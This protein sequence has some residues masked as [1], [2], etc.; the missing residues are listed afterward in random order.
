MNEAT[1]S[2]GAFTTPRRLTQSKTLPVVFWAWAGAIILVLELNIWGNWIFGPNFTPT[3]PGPDPI[4]ELELWYLYGIQALSVLFW[5]YAVWAWIL[6]PSM[7]EGKLTTDAMLAICCWTMWI[8]DPS[9]NYNTTTVLYNSYAVNMGSWTLGSWPGWTSPAG[10]LLP[11]PI[12]V[13]ATGYLCWVYLMVVFPCFLLKKVK[14]RY[15]N[16]GFVPMLALLIAGVMLTDL[17][18][19]V[20]ILR[21]GV[22][23]YPGGIREVTLFAGETYQFPLTEMLTFGGAVAVVAALRFFKNDKGETFV[24][25][26]LDSLNIGQFCQQWIKF[27]GLFGFTHTAFFLVFF[28]PN[29]WFATHSDPWPEGYPSYMINGMCKYGDDRNQCPGPG[30]SI[31]RPENNPF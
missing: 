14:A 5:F 25:R 30:I 24:D 21:T 18:V 7:Q 29:M 28:V 15:P 26:G 3:D 8:W 27:L 1:Q 6:K 13:L 16:L 12:L 2:M 20:L 17:V 23:A 19:E 22:Y 31:P 10:N 4:S 11:E 9:M